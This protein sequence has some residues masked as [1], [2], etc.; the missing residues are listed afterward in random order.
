MP[1]EIFRNCQMVNVTYACGIDDA[2]GCRDISIRTAMRVVGP[3][4]KTQRMVY[5]GHPAQDGIRRYIWS[6][7]FF[8][9]P[10]LNSP[11]MFAKISHLPIGVSNCPQLRENPQSDTW[12]SDSRMDRFKPCI[13]DKHHHRVSVSRTS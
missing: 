1:I 6:C 11:A 4:T 13:H 9:E 12:S 3:C 7:V 2:A 10:S 5:V 8:T